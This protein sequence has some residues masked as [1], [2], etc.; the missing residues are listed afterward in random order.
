MKNTIESTIRKDANEWGVVFSEYIINV[1]E[2]LGDDG[3]RVYIRPSDRGGDT[4]DF[5]IKD[6]EIKIMEW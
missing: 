1:Q 6:N 4:V 5:I 2:D 3:L